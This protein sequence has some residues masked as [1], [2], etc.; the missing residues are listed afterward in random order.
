MVALAATEEDVG[1]A[2]GSEFRPKRSAV[3]LEGD[4]WGMGAGA[5]EEG[6]RVGYIVGCI[7][8]QF[9][10]IN[11]CSNS[12]YSRSHWNSTTRHRN[13]TLHHLKHLK[14]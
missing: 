13:R 9:V 4:S 7:Q 1:G 8:R 5:W 3:S 6:G 11:L 12:Y 14:P 2:L 10:R